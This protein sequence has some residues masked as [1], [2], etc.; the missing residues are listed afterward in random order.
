MKRSSSSGQAALSLVFLIGGIV[1]VAGTSI[2]LF[3]LTFINT[4]YG[5]ET[6]QHVIAVA[7]SGISDALLQLDR[8][9]AF[10]NG[11]GSYTVPVDTASATVTVTQGSPAAN[12]ATI[13]S[14]ATIGL[15]SRTIRAVVSINPTTGQITLLSQQ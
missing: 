2:A 5:Y 6:S 10:P 1:F 8:D 11:G 4:G 12:Q 3:A 14:S 7:S 9:K 13:I 15:R